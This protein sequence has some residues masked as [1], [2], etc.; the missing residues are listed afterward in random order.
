MLLSDTCKNATRQFNALKRL[1]KY[2]CKPGRLTH[3]FCQILVSFPLTW[4]LC[5]K[6]HDQKKLQERA[7][8]L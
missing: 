7:F 1:D 2:L 5:G 8:K 6:S 3:L 4:H